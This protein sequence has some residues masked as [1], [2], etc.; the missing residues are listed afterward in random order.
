MPFGVFA[1]VLG[2]GLIV[3][4]FSEEMCQNHCVLQHSGAS[5]YLKPDPADEADEPDWHKV[6]HSR[7]LG[8]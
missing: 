3:N 2:V 8:P 6:V 1:V 5:W 4:P 7:Q